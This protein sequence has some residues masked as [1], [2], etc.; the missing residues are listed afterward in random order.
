MGRE[1]K[2]LLGDPGSES[3]LGGREKRRAKTT[4]K[5]GEDN[6]DDE[7]PFRHSHWAKLIKNG[8]AKKRKKRRRCTYL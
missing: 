1:K 4:G 8:M 7:K 6:G 2:S 3:R 5:K